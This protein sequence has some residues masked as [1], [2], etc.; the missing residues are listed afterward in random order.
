M[1]APAWVRSCAL[2]IYQLGFNFAIGL[3]TLFWGWLGTRYGLQTT[4]LAAAATGLV[5]ALLARRFNIDHEPAATLSGDT[6]LPA[7][8]AVD[9]DMAAV[10]PLARGQVRRHPLQQRSLVAADGQPRGAAVRFEV[11]NLGA[12]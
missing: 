7:P 2:A 4:M 9:P 6:A 11:V 5:L 3:G 1:A 10:V 8:E 12:G